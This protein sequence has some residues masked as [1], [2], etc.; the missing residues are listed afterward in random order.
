MDHPFKD[1][2]ILFREAAIKVQKRWRAYLQARGPYRVT[3][4]RFYQERGGC[5]NGVNCSYAHGWHDVRPK[6][7][8]VGRKKNRIKPPIIQKKTEEDRLISLIGTISPEEDSEE[9][10]RIDGI[11]EELLPRKKKRKKIT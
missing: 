4:C 3:R 7:V 1:E 8:K 11:Y 10:S 9:E 2:V 6:F 5:R